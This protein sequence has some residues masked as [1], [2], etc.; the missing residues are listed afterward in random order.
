MPRLEESDDEN[1][2]RNNSEIAEHRDED[3]LKAVM[4]GVS[5]ADAEQETE[6]EE[7]TTGIEAVN[8]VDDAA[9]D[10]VYEAAEKVIAKGAVEDST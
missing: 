1:S 3:G 6:P 5:A 10:A 7:V 8:G 4:E 2:T 9:E